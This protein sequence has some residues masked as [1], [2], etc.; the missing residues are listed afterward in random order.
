M[1][2]FYLSCPSATAGVAV[3]Y[4]VNG[5]LQSA[6]SRLIETSVCHKKHNFTIIKYHLAQTL[7]SISL[8]I[9]DIG[10]NSPLLSEDILTRQCMYSVV[11]CTGHHL[12]VVYPLFKPYCFY[13]D[14]HYF[15]AAAAAADDEDDE[16]V[17][18]VLSV[19][20]LR[21]T[22]HERSLQHMFTYIKDYPYKCL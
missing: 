12:G 20:T 10:F 14:V 11:K 21:S 2:A 4:H 6:Y 15:Y 3:L 7:Y 16:S 9:F 8:V 1:Y 22:F 5:Q 13:S 17:R 19:S 18:L